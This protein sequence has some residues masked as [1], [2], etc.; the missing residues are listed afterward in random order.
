MSG[1]WVAMLFSTSPRHYICMSEDCLLGAMVDGGR[2]SLPVILS[3]SEIMEVNVKMVSIKKVTHPHSPHVFILL[4]NSF[5]SIPFIK[6]FLSFIHA[7]LEISR[8]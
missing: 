1:E 2:L 5:H 6:S 3:L 8:S 4:N 7:R